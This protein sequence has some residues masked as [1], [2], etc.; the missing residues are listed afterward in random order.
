M[1]RPTVEGME[2]RHVGARLDAGGFEA[3]R[4]VRSGF[5]LAAIGVI[6]LVVGLTGL[7][8]PLSS[9]VFAAIFVVVG[10]L[11]ASILHFELTALRLE[12]DGHIRRE[13]QPYL[14]LSLIAWRSAELTSPRHRTALARA[15]ARTEHDLTA[16]GLPG[17][18][19]LNRVAARPHADL[20]LRL[21][22]RLKALDRPVTPR[23]VLQ[24]ED[25]VTSPESP[26]YARERARELRA[27]LLASIEALDGVP[28]APSGNRPPLAGS[29][30]FQSTGSTNGRWQ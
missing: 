19:P 21:A 14:G 3:P 22:E 24:V 8:R 4:P 30:R 18:S 11:R 15:I 28:D 26:L 10:G 29:E 27:S 9:L 1:S 5:Q 17:A 2:L 7:I 25:L 12:A 20:L 16:A 6:P 13:R 23:G